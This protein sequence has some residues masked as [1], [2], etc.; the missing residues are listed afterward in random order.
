LTDK[1]AFS[2]AGL[3]DGGGGGGPT[4]G[5][6]YETVKL[7]GTVVLAPP[8]VS[9]CK[10]TLIDNSLSTEKM[11]SPLSLSA[12]MPVVATAG[13]VSAASSKMLTNLTPPQ[14]SLAGLIVKKSLRANNG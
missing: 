3:V 13:T 14:L 12:M 2:Q 7:S 11:S 4:G 1:V 5:K 9:T 6:S 10:Y 8:M